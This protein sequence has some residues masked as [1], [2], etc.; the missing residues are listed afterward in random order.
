MHLK[1]DKTYFYGD[2]MLK[3]LKWAQGKK[4]AIKY[5]MMP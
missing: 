2:L 4:A 3:I 5:G 1:L